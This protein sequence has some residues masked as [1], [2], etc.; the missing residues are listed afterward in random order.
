MIFA[1]TAQ[2]LNHIKEKGRLT[3]GPVGQRTPHV[4][5]PRAEAKLD[6]WRSRRQR[7]L[8]DGQEHHRAPRSTPH[9]LV[10]QTLT[11]PHPRY[12]AL[13]NGG[14]AVV[15]GRPSASLIGDWAKEVLDEHQHDSTELLGQ[16]RGEMVDH[17]ALATTPVTTAELRRGKLATERAMRA[18]RGS[19]AAANMTKVTRGSGRSSGRSRL[20]GDASTRTR[21]RSGS[22]AEKTTS[23]RESEPEWK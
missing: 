23:E 3:G 13:A 19:A 1:K 4:C 12:L 11:L 15:C 2:I 18:H 8:G 16:E 5:D 14:T 7:G 17:R 21:R 20:V 10:P 6:R 22:Y 9:Q